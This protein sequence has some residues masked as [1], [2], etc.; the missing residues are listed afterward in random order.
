MCF[1]VVQAS[2][3]SLKTVG[4]CSMRDTNR[5]KRP[6]VV[7]DEEEA[8]PSVDQASGTQ[9][10]SKDDVRSRVASNGDTLCYR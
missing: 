10:K 7:P 8:P 2:P 9:D 4:Y 3:K 5:L 1:V 6:E